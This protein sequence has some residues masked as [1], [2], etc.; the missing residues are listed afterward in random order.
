MHNIWCLLNAHSY[1]LPSLPFLSFGVATYRLPMLRPYWPSVHVSIIKTCNQNE[2]KSSLS[3]KGF[4]L[5]FKKSAITQSP[6]QYGSTSSESALS[7]QLYFISYWI[8]CQSAHTHI[9]NNTAGKT[10]CNA[11]PMMTKTKPILNNAIYYWSPSSCS[12]YSSNTVCINIQQAEKLC[13]WKKDMGHH[14]SYTSFTDD[15]QTEH[16][17]VS[18]YVLAYW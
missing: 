8:R 1:G 5:W 9:H 10:Q 13:N 3:P 11:R 17:Q 6:A 12:V 18:G 16:H 14:L 4:W 7:F 2:L 15:F